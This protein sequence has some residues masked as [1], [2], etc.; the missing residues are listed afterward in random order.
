MRT[1]RTLCIGVTLRDVRALPALMTISLPTRVKPANGDFPRINKAP[2]EVVSRLSSDQHAL[3]N[4]LIESSD[5]DRWVWKGTDLSAPLRALFLAESLGLLDKDAANRAKDVSIMDITNAVNQYLI[6]RGYAPVA[7]S[8]VY[9]NIYR[10]AKFVHF[11]LGLSIIPNKKTMSVR[12]TDEKTNA[13][14]LDKYFEAMKS[15]MKELVKE[16]EHAEVCQFDTRE[17][18]AQF[19]LETGAVLSLPGQ[20]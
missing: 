1:L 3:S 4:L 17:W 14:N 20:N 6:D 13:Q 15:K 11:A 2:S 12:L 16:M 19:T 9:N 18:R 8:T 7:E 5:W 10:A